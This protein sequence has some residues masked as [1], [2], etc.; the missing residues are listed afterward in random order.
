MD[1]ANSPDSI[2]KTVASVC[3]EVLSDIVCNVI[4]AS[5]PAI[6]ITENGTEPQVL[7]KEI[8]QLRQWIVWTTRRWQK[9]LNKAE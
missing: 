8:Y 7:T 2:E 6:V 9:C 4:Q 3:K 5:E 1:E